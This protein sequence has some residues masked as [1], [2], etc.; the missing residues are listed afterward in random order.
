[1]LSNIATQP[2]TQEVNEFHLL[3]RIPMQSYE[4]DLY[5]NK[6]LRSADAGGSRTRMQ[7]RDTSTPNRRKSAKKISYEDDSL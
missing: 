2:A 1:M 4:R 7:R 3:D 5:K 6:R